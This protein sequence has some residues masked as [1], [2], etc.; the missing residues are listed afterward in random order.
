VG[1]H[2]IG[3][4]LLVDDEISVVRQLERAFKGLK[5]A[6]FTAGN[7]KEALLAIEQK[8]DLSV[9]D[10]RLGSEN[11]L[12]L[13]LELKNHHPHVVIV[14]SGSISLNDR[15]RAGRAGADFLLEKP[16]S[17]S[18]ILERAE[19]GNSLSPD[20]P[21]EISLTEAVDSRIDRALADSNGNI[22]EAA[23]RLKIRRWTLQKKLRK[24]VGR[25]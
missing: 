22:S 13:V 12:D 19:T 14:L 6:V 11:G 5:C 21:L 17:A 16:C 24:R 23:R 4:V 7:Q 10:I 20:D 9:V 2:T 15:F 8:P 1:V 3:K 18:E 25:I